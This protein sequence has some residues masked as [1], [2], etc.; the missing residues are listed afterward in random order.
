MSDQKGAKL[1]M[2]TV[3]QHPG[4]CVAQQYGKLLQ[5]P[6]AKPVSPEHLE[7]EWP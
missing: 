2:V 4:A 5:E 1:P 7:E 3:D 6:G